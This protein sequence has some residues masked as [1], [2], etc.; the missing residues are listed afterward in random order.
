VIFSQDEA[1]APDLVW[2]AQDRFE[3]VVGED[4]KLHAAPD[5][6]VE[7]L[8]P[9]SAN[10][11]RDRELKLDLYSR[12]GVPEYWIADYRGRTFEVY[13]RHGD[14]LQLVATLRDGDI[15]TSPLLPGF[16]C[17]VSRLWVP[18]HA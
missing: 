12:R 8:S 7:V 9:G 11:T 13:R 4:G 10:E 15:L 14:R 5:L 17:P 16:A 2:V 1:V 6:M 18:I 3:R